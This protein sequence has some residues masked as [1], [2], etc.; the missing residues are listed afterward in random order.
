M[1][2]AG[3]CTGLVCTF[4]GSVWLTGRVR[5]YALQKKMLDVPNERSSHQ[6]TTPRGGGVAFVG[7]ILVALV[8]LAFLFGDSWRMYLALFGGGSLIGLIGWLDDRHSLSSRIRIVVHFAGAIWAVFWLGGF[9]VVDSGQFPLPLGWLGAVIAVA[10][11]VW[12]TNL[13]N[14]MDGIDGIAGSQAAVVGSV[15]ACLLAVHGDWAMAVVA[16]VLVAAVS[17]FLV[18]NWPP[19]K[20]FMGD[21]GSGFLGFTIAALAVASENRGSMPLAAWGI[22][23]AVF[24]VDATATLIRRMIRGEKWYAPHRQHAYQLI[25]QAGFSH[26]FV[27]CVV[28][29]INLVLAVAAVV[30]VLQPGLSLLTL[31]LCYGGLALLWR[32]ITAR[33]SRLGQPALTGSRSGQLDGSR[34]TALK[35]LPHSTIQQSGHGSK[36]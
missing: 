32:S 4:L 13:F 33:G 1:L 5:A 25:V 30:T 22:L 11:I 15:A 35:R 29:A 28:A 9:G 16:G 7:L 21:V 19:A 14:F 31:P 8:P 3:L 18:W 10:G 36:R 20:I 34:E 24:A 17:G 6:V 27:T 23:M 2:I 26:R 12:S